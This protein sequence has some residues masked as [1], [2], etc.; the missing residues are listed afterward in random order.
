MYVVIVYDLVELNRTPQRE[1]PTG[2][3][4]VLKDCDK[5]MLRRHENQNRPIIGK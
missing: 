5:A 1:G 3:G 2:L 4:P